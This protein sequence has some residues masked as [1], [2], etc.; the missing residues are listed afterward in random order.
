MNRQRSAFTLMEMVF[1]IVVLGILAGVATVRMA[2]AAQQ[3]HIMQKLYDVNFIMKD[4][5]NYY[6]LI[7]E[8][9]TFDQ[10]T[11]IPLTIKK[12]RSI[13]KV[14]G[15]NCVVFRVNDKQGAMRVSIN[16][17]GAGK[18]EICNGLAGKLRAAGDVITHRY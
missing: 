14:E 3:A 18:R 10:M 5:Q 8:F 11:D 15:N 13:Y 4:V 17:N 6:T 2:V 12:N 9:G 1:V 7:G 16:N